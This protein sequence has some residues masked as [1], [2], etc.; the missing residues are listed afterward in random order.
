M[1]RRGFLQ[2]ILV[3]GVAPAIVKAESLMPIFVRRGDLL[4]P[5]IMPLESVIDTNIGDAFVYLDRAKAL[6]VLQGGVVYDLSFIGNGRSRPGPQKN[7][8]DGNDLKDPV[9]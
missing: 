9:L 1:N 5:D 2:A 4:V 3:A 7:N 8:D 6:K